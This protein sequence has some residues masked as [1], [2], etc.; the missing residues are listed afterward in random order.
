MP[1]IGAHE[2]AAG[3]TKEINAGVHA[4]FGGLVSI[5]M[6]GCLETWIRRNGSNMWGPPLGSIKHVA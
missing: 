6:T 2:E 1:D 4:E 3:L 5:P